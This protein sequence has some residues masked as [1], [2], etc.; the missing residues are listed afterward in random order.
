[1]A[2][3]APPSVTATLARNKLP[4]PFIVFFV[5]G[6][7]AV[8]T[9]IAGPVT[10]AYQV[11]GF[12]GIPIAFLIVMVILAI[13]GAGFV[14]MSRHVVN[15]GAFYSYIKLGLGRPAGVSAAA[16]A[17]VT[18]LM[19]EIGLLGGFGAI[20]STILL[21]GYG[22]DV[23]W[24]LLALIAWALVS[25]LGSRGVTVNGRVLMILLGLELAV[26]M[27]YDAVLLAHPA[28]GHYG[29]APLSP[30]SLNHPGGI[31]VF[32][33]LLAS[34][35]PI[36]AAVAFAEE[37]KRR[38]V[39]RGFYWALGITGVLFAV[40]SWALPVATGANRIQANAVGNGNELMFNLVKPYVG[41]T[42][43]DAGHLFFLT[44]LLAGALAFHSIAARYLFALGRERVAPGAFGRVKP[45]GAPAVASRWVSLVALLALAL[46]YVLKADP[47]VTLLFRLTVVAGF[48]VLLL[49]AATS[50]AVVAFFRGSRQENAWRRTLAPS[51]ATLLL[52]LVAGGAATQFPTLLAVEPGDWRGWAFPAS[53]ALVAL[54]GV[55]YA[56]FLRAR[57]P[58][59]Y[60]HI[61][62]GASVATAPPE[63]DLIRDPWDREQP[64]DGPM[65]SGQWRLD[66][67]ARDR[68]GQR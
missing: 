46:C 25:F 14:A 33:G 4:A 47:A 64:A 34:Y 19:M 57:R 53:F 21:V 1:M 60:A 44:S 17:V 52:A 36:E 49:M 29:L 65:V 3:T 37:A 67:F 22:L 39:A 61:G 12:I 55:A 2:R 68:E 42:L 41:Q 16:V 8:L 10:T 9:V 58:E 48:G 28:H 56:L 59:V 38:A 63:E 7:A 24:I 50:V 15:A 32:A 6:G 66:A 27:I 40:S 43:V 51:L 13:F 5:V 30:A 11:T 54:I 62:L 45:N 35:V 18:Y 26:L 20:A 31:I 23:P